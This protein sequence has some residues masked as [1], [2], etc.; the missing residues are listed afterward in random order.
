[1]KAPENK[2][3]PLLLVLLL[4]MGQI[5]L[6]ACNREGRGFALPPGDIEKGKAAYITFSCNSCHT[7]KGVEYKGN[8]ENIEVPLGGDVTRI[9]SYGELVTSVINPSHKIAKAYKKSGINPDGSSKMKVYNEVMT[10][11]ELV[12]TVT[13]LQSEYRIEAP[14][15]HY[16]QYY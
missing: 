16:P 9:K 11:R 10:V 13:Y 3:I 15:A 12:N 5:L 4:A 6:T 14:P 2:L 1:M 8:D 7:I